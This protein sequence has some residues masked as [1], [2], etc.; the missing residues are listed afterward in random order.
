MEEKKVVDFKVEDGKLKILVDTNKDGEPVVSL[1]VDIAE[2]PDEVV[3]ALK[4]QP[5]WK[6]IVKLF[7][8]TLFEISMKK[9]WEWWKDYQ[10]S[11][12]KK[13]I[14]Q[15]IDDAEKTKNHMDRLKKQQ[16]VLDELGNQ[17][18]FTFADFLWSW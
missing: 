10:R 18:C 14:D 16:D 11:K 5:M 4:K 1:V 17:F 6:S 12:R 2:I 8:A 13:Q 9:I 7:F 15:K 3:S